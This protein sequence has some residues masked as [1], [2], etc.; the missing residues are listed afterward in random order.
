MPFYCLSF[1]NRHRNTGRA[2]KFLIKQ[3][4]GVQSNLSF[5]INVQNI[6]LISDALRDLVPFVQSKK[7]EKRP[8]SSFTLS[9]FGSLYKRYQMV[10]RT[11]YLILNTWQKFGTCSIFWKQCKFRYFLKIF[12]NIL[13]MLRKY[14]EL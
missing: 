1:E 11:S 13:K 8:W 12:C 9:K 6:F 4:N 2:N 7:S 3:L 14:M 5:L 10:Q